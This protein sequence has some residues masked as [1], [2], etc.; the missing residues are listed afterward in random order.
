M[1]LYPLHGPVLQS[2]GYSPVFVQ[3][4]RSRGSTNRVD[5]EFFIEFLRFR[6]LA[7]YKRVVGI[8][9]HH[10]MVL[11]INKRWMTVENRHTEV[12]I[13][14][15]FKWS[16]SQF[17]VPVHLFV[18]T[19]S[20]MPLPHDGSGIAGTFH[21]IRN[22]GACRINLQSLIQEDCPPNILTARILTSHQSIT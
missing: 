15:Q 14:S 3:T 16:G 13:E 17:L 11:H 12:I 20:K 10:M 6:P 9:T 2:S 19:E 8:I 22:C 5:T 21:H 1:F 7:S 4:V 18:R